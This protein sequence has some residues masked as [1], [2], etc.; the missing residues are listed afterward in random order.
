MK[1]SPRSKVRKPSRAVSIVGTGSYVP[2][3]VLTNAELEKMVDTTDE[4]IVSRTGIKERRIA[5]E[6]EFT[7][8]M[9]TKAAQ[10]AMEQ[11]GVT[12]EE[13]QLI[14]VATVTPDTF[15]PSTAC[16][17]QRQLG[18]KNAACFDISAACSGF[19]YGIEVA[20]QFISNHTYE[21]ILVIGADRLSSIVNWNDRNTCVLFGDGAG[22]AILR[23]RAES[24]GVINTFM[25]SDGNYGDILH[26]PGGGCAV[27]ITAENVDQRLNTLHMNGRETFKQAV[28]SMMAAANTALD[29]AGLKVEDLTCV[30]PHQA[31]LRI[32]EALADRMDLP[33]ERFHMNLDKYGNTSAAAVAIAL[34]EANRLGRFKVGDYI[35]MVVFGGGLTYASSVVQW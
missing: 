6:G 34:D 28:I 32:I 7:S 5:A 8:H 29:R 11:A 22:A 35:L 1:N 20:Q 16:H 3:K 26:M 10:R 2:E 24:H 12:A 17:V 25:G 13:I 23:Y 15:F 9:A 21:T 14:V 33:L 27:P 18:A 30:I 31:N 4:W 19:L